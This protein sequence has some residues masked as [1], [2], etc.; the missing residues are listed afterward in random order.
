MAREF[1]LCE[2]CHCRPATERHHVFGAANRK[3][4]EKY[5]L[6]AMLCNECHT[7][8]NWAVHNHRASDLKLK[9]RYQQI[10]ERDHDRSLFISEFGRNYL[11]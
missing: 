6:I 1:Q 5:K 3:R 10:F 11:D 8:G 2:L 4:S 7:G 9:I